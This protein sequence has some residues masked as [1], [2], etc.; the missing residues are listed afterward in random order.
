[1][2]FTAHE[3][4]AVILVG[5]GSS[6]MG[7]DK[8]ALDWGGARAVDL[9]AK[10]AAAVGAELILTSGGD[11]GWPYVLDERAGPVGGILAGAARLTAEGLPRGLFLA[12]DAPTIRPDDLAPLLDARAPGAAFA[13]YPLPAVIDLA[14]IPTK[15]APGWP[16]ARLVERCGLGQIACP[17]GADARLR[18]ANTAAERQ[19][20]L[21]ALKGSADGEVFA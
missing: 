17:K 13:G 16:I 5:G 3:F 14:A 10:L 7:R 9:T 20:L 19:A 6:R 15:A 1:V 11:Y 21:A 8:A 4:G 12:V 18:G 2:S